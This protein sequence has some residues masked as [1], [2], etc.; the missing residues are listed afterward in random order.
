VL[1]DVDGKQQ[2]GYTRRIANGAAFPQCLCLLTHCSNWFVFHYLTNNYHCLTMLYF[3][4]DRLFN[5]LL[6]ESELRLKESK[7]SLF[8]FLESLRSMEVPAPG[9][10]ITVPNRPPLTVVRPETGSLSDYALAPLLS[11]FPANPII[12]L[13]A[14]LLFERRI[15]IISS[16]LERISSCVQAAVSALYPFAWHHIFIPV[17]PKQLLAYCSAPMPFLIGLHTSLL[18]PLQA[19]P[20]NE[21]V[22]VDL[23][24]EVVSSNPADVANLP[25]TIVGPL[26]TALEAATNGIKSM[27]Q[28]TQPRG[29]SVLIDLFHTEN[30]AADYTAVAM[31]FMYFFVKIFAGYKRFFVKDLTRRP[32]RSTFDRE[33]FV[34]SQ[35]KAVRKVKKMDTLL[36]VQSFG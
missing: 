25:P 22:F 5:L 1:T 15:I 36:I 20:L 8:S 27:S 21:V 31:A 13:F 26:R 32:I 24:K 19:M 10:H 29:N 4:R 7:E 6:H 16:D 23:D 3:F 35:N 34:T 33:T 17:L 11:T 9:G 28:M 30:G 14:S 18:Q 12:Q 2:I